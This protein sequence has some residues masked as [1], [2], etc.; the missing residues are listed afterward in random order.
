[1]GLDERREAIRKLQDLRRSK[2]LVHFLSDRRIAQ[3]IPISGMNAQLA[4]EPYRLIYEHIRTIGTPDRLDLFLHTSGGLLD[5]VWPLVSLCRSVSKTFSVLVPMHALSAGTLLC[6]GADN[7]IM[8]KPALLSPID[9]TTTTAFNPRDQ[10]RP[11]PISVEDVTSYFDLARGEEEGDSAG[12]GLKSDE[13]ILEV[14]RALT[15]QVHPLALGNVKRVHSQ[16]RQLATQLLE[17]HIRGDDAEERVKRI[18]STLTEKLYSHAHQIGRVEAAQILG[19]DTVILPSEQEEA[20]MW[21]LY[22]HYEDLFELTHTFNLKDWMA[23]AQERDLEAIGGVIESEG[24]SHVFKA[25]SKVRQIS[26][27]PQGVQ[28]QIPPGQRMPLI[29]GLPI[30]INL[31]PTREGWY[32]NEEGV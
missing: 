26:D 24:A 19:D 20:A 10:N 21:E 17:L 4:P 2:L 5:S 9:P 18:V 8:C 1:M 27:L 3:G 13:H 25:M 12:I 30:K 31:E 16:I 14:F 32:L 22:G 15:A 29:P 7:V 28:V 6:L 23:G 11:I